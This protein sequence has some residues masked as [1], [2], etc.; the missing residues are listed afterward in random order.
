MPE[1]EYKNIVFTN[2]ALERLNSRHI[3]ADAVYNVVNWADESKDMGQGKRK[4]IRTFGGR[5]IHVVA[6][7]KPAKQHWVVV[8]VWVRGEDDKQPLA[9]ILI[10]APFKII[11]TILSSVVRMTWRYIFKMYK[12]GNNRN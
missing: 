5:L 3:T 9:W 12:S 11:W 2:H 8:S 7:H 1:R 6:F 10:T 4:F